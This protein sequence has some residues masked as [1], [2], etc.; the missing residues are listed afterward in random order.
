MIPF[1]LFLFICCVFTFSQSTLG[2]WN[3]TR[4]KKVVAGSELIVLDTFTIYP[5]SFRASVRGVPLSTDEYDLNISDKTFQ[6]RKPIKDTLFIEYQVLPYDFGKK[7][8]KRDTSIIYRV[9]KGDREKFLITEPNSYESIFGSSGLKKSGSISRGVSFGNN[10]NVSLNS[11]LN[12]ELSGELAPNLK[13]MASV[14][15]NNIPI[16]PEG[17]TSKLQEFDQVFIQIYNDKFKLIAGDYWLSKPQGY[18]LNYRKRGQGLNTEFVNKTKKGEWKNGISAGLSKGKYARQVV[19]GLE[20]N[21]GPYRMR[22]N[23]NEPFIIM[24]SGTEKVY[25]D[26]RLLQRGQE[27]DYVVNYNTSEITF[28]SKNIITK[29]VRIVVEFQYTD[30]SYARSLLTTSNAYSSDKLS[31]WFN[32]FSEQDAKN[33]TLQ[34][35]LSTEQKLK[36]AS[37]GDSLQFAGTLSADSV[38]FLENQN[39]YY[40]VD[41]LGF[42]NVLVYSVNPKT[43][44]YQ[45]VFSQVGA[46]KGN[47]VFDRFNALGKIYKWVMPENG[48]PQGD[49]EPIRLLTTPKQKQMV[50]AGVNVKI[51]PKV[52]LE[53]EWGYSKNDINTFST[54][55]KA[56]DEG[57]SNKSKISYKTPFGKDSIKP[58]TWI[59]SAE[60]EFLSTHFAPIELFRT[61][62]FDRDWNTRGKG[63]TGSQLS[64]GAST[65]IE[66]LSRGKINLDATNYIVGSDYNGQ[67]LAWNGRWKQNGFQADWTS[68]MLNSNHPQLVNKFLRY[69]LTMSQKI[70]KI[71]IGYADDQEDNRYRND[72]ILTNQS[73]GFYDYQFFIANADSAAFNYK[74]F[75]RERLD[76]R[77]DTTTFI[78]V[79]KARNTGFDM[80]ILS[81]KNQRLN[82]I[83]NYRELKINQPKYINQTPENTLL[84]RVDYDVNLCKGMVSWN[85]FYEIGS[86]LELK[87]E[88]LYV[89]VNDGQGVYT[90]ID[91]NQDGI[92]DLNE[93]EVAQFVDQASYIR[94]FTPSN[95]YVNSYSNELNQGIFIKPEKLWSNKKGIRKSL[96][97]FSDQMR[98]RINRKTSSFDKLNGFNP[99]VINISDTALIS[100]NYNFR[101]T[102]F[103]NRNSAIF[104]ADLTYQDIRSKSLLATGF[105]ARN[106]HS[107]E[108][109]L[110]WN[111]NK[112]ILLEALLSQGSKQVKADYTI[113]RNYDLTFKSYKPSISYQPSTAVRY[114]VDSRYVQKNALT[115]ETTNIK[116]LTFRLKYNQTE[117]GSLQGSF[118]LLQIQFNGVSTSALGFEMLE[119]LKPGRNNTWTLGYQRS[120]SKKI[121]ISI[122]YSGRN[123]E[124]SRTIHA[125]GMEVRA[126]F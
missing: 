88:F 111:P 34:Q 14:T 73:Y 66:H 22:G 80:S 18:F 112:V 109:N 95:Q 72:S 56:N 123:S 110:R 75:Y 82:I 41:T 46:N 47:Y 113:G 78:N 97:L 122:Q 57:Y 45:A 103:F 28:T 65:G 49:Y 116:E 63:Y 29:D 44:V 42:N 64:I 84:G 79:A 51:S 83:V 118:S 106:Q 55:D 23:E 61:M 124:S 60:T 3:N 52:T 120:V 101:N 91:Y 98:M 1:R 71:K 12:L 31:V 35:S 25:I 107:T 50:T 121:Q 17:N 74:V 43:A 96:A 8:Q 20:G 19:Q 11:S 114:T 2:Q 89:K 58:W 9:N 4:K 105:D 125:G 102:L 40:K 59:T 26:G 115:G 7:Y 104:G 69:K 68:S 70:G 16:Q 126:F 38:G 67:K 77:S 81:L 37:I 39:M 27:N 15:D 85:T 108:L 92:K 21:Q 53:T 5:L 24:L 119:A 48:I 99:F 93:F 54:I 33:Q 94:V 30:Q 90:W 86:G 117:K 10:Q 32:A 100:T 13:I 6:L 87:R 76:M 62:E 36:M